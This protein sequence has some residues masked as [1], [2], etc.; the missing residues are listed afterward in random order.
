M[1]IVIDRLRKTYGGKTVLDLPHCEIHAG[2]TVGIVGNNGAGKTTLFRLMLDMTK[3]DNGAV[4]L[5]GTDVSSSERWKDSVGAYL[6]ESFL[7]DYLTPQ[8][9]FNLMARLYGMPDEVMEARL[10]EYSGFLAG[11]D[12]VYIR[13]LSAGERQKV[14]IVASLLHVPSLVVMD[15]PFN[16]LDPS[17]QQSLV[18]L[19]SRYRDEHPDSTIIISSH[20]IYHVTQ[21]TTR[22]CL[23]EQGRI[24][25]DM[26]PVNQNSIRELQQYFNIHT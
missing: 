22:L 16:F 24:I 9:Y 26:K 12:E 21:V 1:D 15:E 8:E 2:E 25:R 6:D 17:S 13:D 23:M 7:I 14:G 19:I 10:G 5:D 3:A 11:I 4:T 18:R 20:D